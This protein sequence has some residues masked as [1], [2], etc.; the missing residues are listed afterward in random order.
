MPSLDPRRRLQPRRFHYEPRFLNPQEGA[1][2]ERR[3]LPERAPMGSKTRLPRLAAVA[4][5]LAV[6][7]YLY[8]NLDALAERAAAVGTALFGG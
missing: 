6:A 3:L 7:L 8:L 1:R 2:V 5:A 4:V